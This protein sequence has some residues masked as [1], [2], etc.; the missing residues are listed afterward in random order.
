MHVRKA[1]RELSKLHVKHSRTLMLSHPCMPFSYLMG[2]LQGG[3]FLTIVLRIQNF[4]DGLVFNVLVY[5][6]VFCAKAFGGRDL[7]HFVTMNG[8]TGSPMVVCGLGVLPRPQPM[9]W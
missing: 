4:N 1:K 2:L 9:P 6:G 5:F 7:A 8:L 3:F